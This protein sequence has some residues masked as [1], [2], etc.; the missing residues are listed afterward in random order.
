[1]IREGYAIWTQAVRALMLPNTEAEAR[2][3]RQAGKT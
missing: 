2:S 1:M 3:C